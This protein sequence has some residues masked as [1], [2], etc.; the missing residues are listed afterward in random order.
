MN[1]RG[2][3]I[4][5][6]ALNLVLL[7]A[8]GYLVYL[9][10]TGSGKAQLPAQGK[11]VTNTV[12]QIA[13]RK[14]NATN[15]LDALSKRPLNWSAIESTN[16][17]VYIKN[18]QGIGCPEETVRDIILTDVA[19]F[20]A[21]RKVALR[22]QGQPFRFWQTGEGW[23]G[24]FNPQLQRQLRELEHEQRAL[25]RE[26]I[27]VEFQAEMAKYLGDEDSQQRLY[28]FLS[29]DKQ[30]KVVSL[31]SKYDELEHDIY[32][33]SK[34]W[35]L[36]EDQEQLRKLQQQKEGELAEILKP[37][38]LDEYQ[39]RNSPTANSLRSQLAGFEPTE[40]EFRGIFRFQHV[41]DREFEQAFNS[42]DDAQMEVKTR[43]QQQAQ[44]ALRDEVKKILGDKRFAEY[45]RAQDEDYK[46]LAQMADRFEMPKAIA[47]QVYEMKQAAE[48]QRQRI[49]TDPNLTDE[50]R[51]RGLAAIAHETERSVTE[52]LGDKVARAYTRSAGQWIRNLSTPPEVPTAVAGFPPL[53]PPLKVK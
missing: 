23:E 8:V 39:L 32:A 33:R 21:K 4:G 19:K 3:S 17:T 6:L 28:G 50:Q 41:F 44:D 46:A 16:Y 14:I 31:Q 38:E 53:P 25:I 30:A 5:L 11:V 45:Q 34:G 42:S 13:V 2:I 20:Y 49:E 37:E 27:G 9:L 7:T 40:E 52:A 12:T 15:L 29:P 51:Q 18:L 1:S 47:G 36:D 24:G 48:A 10:Q 35:M 43:A 26:L 22:G